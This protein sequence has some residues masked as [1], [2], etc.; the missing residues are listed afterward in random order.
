MV[1]QTPKTPTKQW[2][3]QGRWLKRLEELE[4]IIVARER[5]EDI[6]VR[7]STLKWGLAQEIARMEVGE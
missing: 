5:G 1:M 6:G 3:A 7:D 4:R 2:A